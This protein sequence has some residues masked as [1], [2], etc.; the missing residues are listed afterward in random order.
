MSESQKSKDVRTPDIKVE[1]LDATSRF[2]GGPFNTVTNKLKYLIIL[3]MTGF[4]GYA[5]YVAF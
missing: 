5:I 3:A 2:F 1:E 4:G